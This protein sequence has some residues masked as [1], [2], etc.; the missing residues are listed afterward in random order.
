MPN[1]Q[2]FGKLKL[3]KKPFSY[4]SEIGLENLQFTN[5]PKWNTT[6]KSK[7]Y[8]RKACFQKHKVLLWVPTSQKKSMQRSVKSML[9][10]F[11]TRRRNMIKRLS[12]I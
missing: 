2:P 3:K 7:I 6:L 9:I 11:T 5:L 8:W 4:K 12:N 1:F 10:N